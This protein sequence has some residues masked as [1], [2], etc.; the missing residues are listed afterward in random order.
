MENLDR[1]EQIQQAY[2]VLFRTALRLTGNE[3]DATE[4]TQEAICKAVANWDAFG[5]RARRTTWLYGILV[6]C[7]RDWAR[8][9]SA[10]RQVA[11]DQWEAVSI[12]DAAE[13]ALLQRKAQEHTE[14]LRQAIETLPDRLRR[15]FVLTVMDG[16]SYEDAA[17]TL[18]VPEGTIASRVNAARARLAQAMRKAFPDDAK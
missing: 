11:F 16:L 17:E 8:R 5:G 12:G 6:N 1:D 10:D 2:P 15:A 7:V 4:M 13:A 3:H 14:A 9:K 18:D